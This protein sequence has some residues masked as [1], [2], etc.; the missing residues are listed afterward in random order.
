MI[1]HILQDSNDANVCFIGIYFSITT[2]GNK[3]EYF[4]G[5]RQIK[6]IR[7]DNGYTI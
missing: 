6:N 7:N 3:Y 4:I 1:C 2:Q 5:N